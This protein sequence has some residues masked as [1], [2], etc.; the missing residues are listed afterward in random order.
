MAARTGTVNLTDCDNFQSAAL[1]PRLNTFA[2]L[3]I[4]MCWGP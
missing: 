2:G 3:H 4:Y 1:D